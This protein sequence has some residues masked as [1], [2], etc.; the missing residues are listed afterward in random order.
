M[1]REKSEA[2][3]G[4]RECVDL[5]NVDITFYKNLPQDYA[6]LTQTLLS[7]SPLL[8]QRT[9]L[10]NLPWVA[11]AEEEMKR[12]AAEDTKGK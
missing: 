7:L 12:R 6:T 8:S 9:I 2:Q 11:D 5:T 10:E 3:K 4:R 1:G